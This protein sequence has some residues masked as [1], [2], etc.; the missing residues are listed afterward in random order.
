MSAWIVAAAT[1][2][3]AAVWVAGPDDRWVLDRRLGRADLPAA[4]G[5]GAMVVLTALVATLLL[6]VPSTPTRLAVGACAA[7]GWFGLR[8]HRRATA[9]AEARAFS[10]EVAQVVGS[11]SATLRA[12]V[13][14]VLAV[15]AA[16]AEGSEVWR[17]LRRAVA[18]DVTA[19][20]RR[21]A[22]RPGGAAL[23]EAA[24]AW[25]I[26]D[27]TGA[28]LAGILDRV[29]DGIRGDLE[30]EREITAEAVPAWATGR[31]MAALPVVGLVLATTMGAN[32]VR[33][34]L[35]TVPGVTCLVVGLV[36]A[37]TGLWWI[38]R[39][40]SAVERR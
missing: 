19:A 3:T 14:P 26:A 4:P 12:G 16:A 13:T 10:A 24:A 21:L 20:L 28:P 1:T 36:L 38:D 23:V 22:E 7:G 35:G 11:L 39:I 15:Q 8:L 29:A 5:F 18:A 32:P 30:I 31:L 6:L 25:E 40:V 33:V 17:P 2:L 34:L 37:G 9:R 27:R